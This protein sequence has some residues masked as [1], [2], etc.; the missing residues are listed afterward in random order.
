MSKRT[1]TEQIY[2]QLANDHF[3]LD[4]EQTQQTQQQQKKSELHLIPRRERDVV[5]DET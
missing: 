1:Q 5:A 3:T 4:E 2:A